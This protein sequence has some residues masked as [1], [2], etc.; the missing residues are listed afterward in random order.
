MEH[1]VE[2]TLTYLNQKGE[3]ER[4]RDLGIAS[5]P[6]PVIVLGE[7]G[8]GKTELLTQIGELPN[9][10]FRSAAAFVAHPNP[11]ALVQPAPSLS[12]GNLVLKRGC[13]P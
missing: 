2:R 11:A 1:Y 7:P 3:Q 10:V 4:L 9:M 6:E 5:I 12:A 13:R 8:M